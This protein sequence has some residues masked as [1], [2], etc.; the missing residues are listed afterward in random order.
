MEASVLL[1]RVALCRANKRKRNRYIV[2]LLVIGYIGPQP[3]LQGS[4]EN[5]PSRVGSHGVALNKVSTLKA[6]RRISGVKLLAP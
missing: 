1:L 3:T 6:L 5:P 2:R 4:R